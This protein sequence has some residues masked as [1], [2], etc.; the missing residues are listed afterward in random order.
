MTRP[1]PGERLRDLGP[2][3]VSHTVCRQY[4]AAIREIE[5]RR[6]DMG[7]AHAELAELLAEAYQTRTPTRTGATQWRRRTGRLD[8]Q[9]QVDIRRDEVV[10]THVHVRRR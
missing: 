6:L 2:I 10:I 4:A 7:A 8:I 9:A 3:W 5:G 1:I